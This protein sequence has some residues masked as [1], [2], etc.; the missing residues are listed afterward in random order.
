MRTTQTVTP[1]LYLDN[2]TGHGDWFL[3]L[4]DALGILSQF[5]R[6]PRSSVI[7]RGHNDG[8]GAG[9]FALSLAKDRRDRSG[10]PAVSR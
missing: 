6:D 7:P 2:P 10:D 1:Q 8:P 3:V 5:R 9:A 4:E